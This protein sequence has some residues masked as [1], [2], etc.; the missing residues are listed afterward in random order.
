[1]IITLYYS[2]EIDSISD[3]PL[4]VLDQGLGLRPCFSGPWLD[5]CGSTPYT[6]HSHATQHYSDI[7][8]KQI[9]ETTIFC[10]QIRPEAGEIQR[11]SRQAIIEREKRLV[12]WRNQPFVDVI[13]N[14]RFKT[15][16][17]DVTS[18]KLGGTELVN[19]NPVIKTMYYNFSDAYALWGEW[20][21]KSH[22]S[23][24]R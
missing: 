20:N 21:M 22:I 18:R 14:H 17:C 5:T 19:T 1:M 16:R 9:Y 2:D 12:N 13:P 3:Q 10:Y 23:I 15:V 24:Y 8:S 6:T 4:S 11:E 7:K